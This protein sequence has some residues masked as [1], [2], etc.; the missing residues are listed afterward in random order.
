[1]ATESL[2]V[3]LDAR[4]AKLDAKLNST[5]DKLDK[6]T[7]KSKNSDSGLKKL[8]NGA[9]IAGTAILQTAAAA[10]AL[11][12][13]VT[14][15]VLSSAKGRRELEL[16]AKQAKT[17]T[18]DFQAL[19]FAT[20]K[21]GINADQIGDISKEI[22][23]KVGEFAA[24]GT[25]A[26]QDY[27]D[28]LKLTKDQ[29]REAAQEFEGLSSQEILGRMI[30]RM[31]EAGVEAG[32]MDFAIDSLASDA[33]RLIPLFSNNSKE[34][35]QLKK[36]FDDV[37]KSLQ[38]TGTQAEAL[39]E[40]SNTFTL[41][42][43][44]AGNA[45]TAISATLAPV[46]DDFF[47]DIIDVVPDATQTIIDFINSFLDAE[48]IASRTGVLQQIEE[49]NENIKQTNEDII[50][51]GP[52]MKGVLDTRLEREKQRLEELKAQL[53][54]LTAQEQKLENANRL[55]GG[56]I[57]GETSAPL[58]SGG[59][60]GLGTGDEIQAIAD[61]FKLEETLLAEKL[62]RELQIIGDNNELKVELEQEFAENIRKIREDTEDDKEKI[63]KKA[64]KSEE[65]I[66]SLKRSFAERTAVTLL[67]SAAT[68]QQKLFSIVK[69]AAA[70]QIE[71][72]GLTAGARAL[73]EL[74]PIAGPP[75]AASYIGWSQVAAG[76]VR[77]LPLGGGGGGAGSPGNGGT[78]TQAQPQQENF[79]PETSSLEL[80]SGTSSGGATN[81]ISFATD[82]GDELINV[83]AKLLEK[84][85]QEGRFT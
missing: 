24:A 60:G 44:S 5:N 21:Y 78:Q 68:T 34:L 83:I 73:A 26:F 40:V 72:Y 76:I 36:R 42:T 16:L 17:S 30:S 80:S 54:V 8:G 13:A 49:A 25:G 75:V 65:K 79:Q 57:G 46:L 58:T 2:I 51:Q 10:A 1:M 81:T 66:E 70:G 15:I 6:L 28:V 37:N 62:V 4:T 48:N 47:N 64:V 9:K 85:K 74:G 33:E 31:E 29:A 35:T 55:S 11:S 27:A 7:E 41:L 18:S 22:S 32:R 53:V 63:D 61:R 43:S 77:A 3:E 12:A 39:R 67:S 23:L 45:T 50:N 19:S 59:G 69:D 14:A 38:I 52:R 56:E 84:G 71:A 20:N 82:S